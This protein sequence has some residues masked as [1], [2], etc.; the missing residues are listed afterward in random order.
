MAV[1]WFNGSARLSGG[2]K[3]T[4]GGGGGV[5]ANGMIWAPV[6]SV[7]VANEA[8]FPSCPGLWPDSGYS[9]WQSLS[10]QA[11]CGGVRQT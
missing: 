2:V 10:G 1:W 6:K 11:Q 4:V 9:A 5:T 7:T 8:A 3:L